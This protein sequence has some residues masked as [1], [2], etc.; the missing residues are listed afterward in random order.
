MEALDCGT[1]KTLLER[2]L[3]QKRYLYCPQD[4]PEVRGW[5]FD[6]LHFD[7]SGSVTYLEWIESSWE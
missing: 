3:E 5:F 4:L 7:L 6:E 2:M 1:F